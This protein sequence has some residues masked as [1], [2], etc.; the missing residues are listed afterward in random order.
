MILLEFAT[1]C[2]DGS[3]RVWQVMDVEGS[4]SV[5]VQLKWSSEPSMLAASGIVLNDTIGLS[6]VNRKLLEQHGATGSS[7]DWNAH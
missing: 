1:A 6:A 2:Q 7:A 3:L 5:S 4:G